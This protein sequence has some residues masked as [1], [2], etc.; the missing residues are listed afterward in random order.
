MHADLL[1]LAQSIDSERSARLGSELGSRPLAILLGVAFPPL[2][3]RKGWQADAVERIGSAG[4][5][6]ARRRRDMLVTLRDAFDGARASGAFDPM[7]A[8][9]RAVWEEKARIALRE[10][11][12]VE[13]G[14]AELESTARELSL[15][16][17]ASLEI[18]MREAADHVAERHGEPR[19]AD[20][21]A[22]RLVVFGMGKLGGLELNAGSD[23]DL[24][25]VYDSDDGASDVSLHEHWTRVVRRAVETLETPTEDG[26]VW[27]VD[28]R[29]RPEGSQGAIANS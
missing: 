26:L 23:V 2:M 29:L 12:P 5:R 9:R 1:R 20:G 17:D 10:L 22:S 25:F 21:S 14:G 27:R 13:L 6:S 4:W 19:R 15:L 16:A 11:L 3:P 18:A 24:V 8:L 7:A 28:L